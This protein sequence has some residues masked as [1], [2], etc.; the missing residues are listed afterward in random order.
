MSTSFYFYIMISKAKF[1]YLFFYEKDFFL[2][3]LA[4]YCASLLDTVYICQEI[5]ATFTVLQGNPGA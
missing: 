4:E 5:L 3:K 2:Q 1:I